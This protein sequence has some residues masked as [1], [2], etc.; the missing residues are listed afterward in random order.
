MVKDHPNNQPGAKKKITFIRRLERQI[1]QLWSK[2][3]VLLSDKGWHRQCRSCLLL[4]FFV[5]D[6]PVFAIVGTGILL[7]LISILRV[8]FQ[9]E[10][11]R[12]L[13]QVRWLVDVS[14]TTEA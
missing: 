3:E 14:E 4:L 8:C 13:G 5:P 1:I 2:S 6:G 10:V 11:L 12:L 9:I 7:I